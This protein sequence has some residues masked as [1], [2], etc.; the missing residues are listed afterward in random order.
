[1]LII[2]FKTFAT[3]IKNIPTPSKL[4]M[5]LMILIRWVGVGNNDYRKGQTSGG[6]RRPG[7]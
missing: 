5:I 4:Y 2:S 1:L 7:S 6:G 3:E